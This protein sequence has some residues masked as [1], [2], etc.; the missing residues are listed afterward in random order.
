M[1]QL[2]Q[3]RRTNAHVHHYSELQG[4][5]IDEFDSCRSGCCFPFAALVPTKY[6]FNSAQRG[7]SVGCDRISGRR[8]SGLC[9]LVSCA[10]FRTRCT[11]C[12]DLVFLCSSLILRA[13]RQGAQ[14]DPQGVESV[15]RGIDASRDTGAGEADVDNGEND[16]NEGLQQDS[17]PQ[18]A[19]A[20]ARAAFPSASLSAF[21][22]YPAAG[23]RSSA[24]AGSS[25]FSLA[26]RA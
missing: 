11:N 4:D 24:A 8:T 9:G 20:A 15:P 2:D 6:D 5:I 1:G 18:G 23:F 26:P 17:V 25:S 22:S 10:C 3:L 13:L 16:L 21:P 7:C 14:Q 19:G 12:G